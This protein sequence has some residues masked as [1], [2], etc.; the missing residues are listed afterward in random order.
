MVAPRIALDP[1]EVS[2]TG[3]HPALRTSSSSAG[4]GWTSLLVEQVTVP[5]GGPVELD[6]PPVDAQRIVLTTAG[7]RRVEAR[8]GRTW[9]G[10]VYGPGSIGLA[11]PGTPTRLRWRDL[12]D[13]R[14]A[15]VQ[16]HLPGAVVR[17][18]AAA[19]RAGGALPDALPDAL[20]RADR[21]L[22]AM[23]HTLVGAVDAGLPELYA[24]GAALF[25][26][27]H[28]VT[29]PPTRPAT[30]DA[31]VDRAVAYLRDHLQEPVTLTEL[32]DHVGLSRYHFLRLFRDRTG[33]T[34]FA[35]LTGIRV[36][37]A[38]RLLRHG[39]ASSTEIAALCGFA[40]P[41]AFS[42]TFRRH[43]GVTP[44][45]YRRQVQGR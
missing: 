16:V 13:G 32:A 30:D 15:E 22:E 3:H 11:A 36:E 4:L 37:E 27:A 7:R 21:G 33:Q 28:L 2:A 25:L 8:S 5:G 10:A 38:Q 20:H 29:G 35:H 31:R 26:A 44:S 18:A 42:A 39:R 12:D 14:V 1:A 34:P 6:V 19:R 43:T 41:S 17:E 45:A 9:R 40:S 23:V 24:E